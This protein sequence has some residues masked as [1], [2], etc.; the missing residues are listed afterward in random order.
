MRPWWL[1]L[2]CGCSLAP[3]PQLL[4]I[5]SD[6]QAA[7]TD[8]LAIEAP[9]FTLVTD[10]RPSLARDAAQELAAELAAIDA[11]FGDAPPRFDYALDVVVFAN[12]LD[13]ER[14][15]GRDIGAVISRPSGEKRVIVQTWGSPDR[16]LRHPIEGSAV[17]PGSTMRFAIAEA[18]MGRQ[19]PGHVPRW[20][21]FGMASYVETLEWSDDWKAI[22]LGAVNGPMLQSY[23]RSRT[24]GFEEATAPR[25]PHPGQEQVYGLA[26]EGYC[27]ALIYTAIHASPRGLNEYMQ[28]LAAGKPAEPSA[29]FDGKSAHDIDEQVEHFIRAAHAALR[30]VPVT[31]YGGGVARMR[32]LTEEELPRWVKPP[33][34]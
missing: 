6:P 12:G 23:R 25:V 32:P 28:A 34:P 7:A 4:R 18:V 17:S 16:W 27:W 11:A 29:V 8:W 3:L 22:S 19:F 15:F 20:F 5:D 33:R 2:L 26:Y 1:M 24:V 10:L 30:R 14:R 31:L 21:Q 13:F 9:G